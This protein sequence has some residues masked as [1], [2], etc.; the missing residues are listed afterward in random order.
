MVHSKQHELKQIKSNIELIKNWFEEEIPRFL[1]NV[2]DAKA[3]KEFCRL[4]CKLNFLTFG[5]Q[6]TRMHAK[7]WKQ[8]QLGNE[9]N[10][11]VRAWERRALSVS[12]I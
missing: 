8:Q 9:I 4:F 7:Y 6:K 3:L 11:I 10:G 2:V 5:C 1:C 12:V